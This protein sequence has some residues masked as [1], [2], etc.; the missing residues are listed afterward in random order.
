MQI[1]EF[2]VKMIQAKAYELSPKLD[3]LNFVKS[4]LPCVFHTVQERIYPE[5]KLWDNDNTRATLGQIMA[6]LAP[7]VAVDMSAIP[8]DFERLAP[9]PV[10][11]PRVAELPSVLWK[12]RVGHQAWKNSATVVGDNVIVGS[13]GRHWNAADSEDGVYCLDATTGVIRWLAPTGA[14]AN[15][16]F[17]DSGIVVTG[18][19]NGSAVAVSVQDGSRLWSVQLDRG[20]VGGPLSSLWL[21]YSKELAIKTFWL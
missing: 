19:D 15:R 18:C 7:N 20:I 10:V 4:N 21:K 5:L 12:A 14:D 1:E 3:K 8:L 2:E 16:V 11:I 13:A 9:M 17:V 6:R